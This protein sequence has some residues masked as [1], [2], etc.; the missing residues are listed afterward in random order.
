MIRRHAIAVAFATGLALGALFLTLR[1]TGP[2]W[3]LYS[4]QFLF[5]LFPIGLVLLV[6]G[7]LLARRGVTSVRP[8]AAVAGLW[9]GFVVGFS[10]LG[11]M[12]CAF[13][14]A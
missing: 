6:V 3:L 2:A 9:V 4:F 8:V 5:T 11:I 12:T 7:G 10:A 1:V 13:C 14:L